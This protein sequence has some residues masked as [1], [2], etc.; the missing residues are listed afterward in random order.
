MALITIYLILVGTMYCIVVVTSR[1]Y[2]LYTSRYYVVTSRYYILYTSRYN[3]IIV[4]HYPQLVNG[5]LLSSI[6]VFIIMNTPLSTSSGSLRNCI[7][8]Q[9]R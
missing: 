4:I 9:C 6:A 2:V 7:C 8:L 5:D 3:G 1:Y